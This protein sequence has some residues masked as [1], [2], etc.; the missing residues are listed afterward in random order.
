MRTN[1]I[2]RGVRLRSVAAG[3]DPDAPPRLVSIPTEWE[4]GAASALAGLVP[5]DGPVKLPEAVEAWVRPIA[6]A[7]Q[8]AGVR[9]DLAIRLHAMLLHRE[10]APAPAFWR[11]IPEEDAYFV[12]NLPA[13]VDSGASFDEEEFDAASETA[14]LALALAAP[15]AR[16]LSLG[17]AD[18]DGFIAA[19]GVPYGTEEACDLARFVIG[20]LR[21]NANRLCAHEVLAERSVRVGAF[22]PGLAEALLGAET[23]GI[24]PSFALVS[25]E[26]R[27]TRAARAFLAARGIGE[28]A[29]LAAELS[30]QS[31][32]PR[33]GHAAHRTMR[34]T[35]AGLL[36]VLPGLPEPAMEAEA[37]APASPGRR[38]L[39]DRHAGYTQ[40]ATLGGHRIYIRTG[41]YPDGTLGELSIALPKD[42]AALRGVM[43][44]FSTAVSIGLQHG[45]PLAEFV[46]AFT[47]LGR[48]GP[49]GVVEGDPAVLR[50]SSVPDYVFRHLA[51]NY[52]GQHDLPVP[53][54]EEPAA[55]Q[56]APLLP[57]DLPADPRAR[58][59]SFRVVSG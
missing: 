49:S 51:A 59:R 14:L 2:W 45:V 47:Q 29:A 12:L 4:D 50:A 58:R 24:A 35:L 53:E 8:R 46:E 43:D 42:S 38:D 20:R 56:P 44:A 54:S 6:L 39:P 28:G 11:G 25:A 22:A 55:P 16:T 34:A 36:D 52:L 41:E 21:A 23:G 33:S 48:F 10:A 5:G 3:A 26:G 37:G 40:K 9:E 32:F 30:G 1:Q 7:A 27:L 17:V 13:F 19:H 18:L 15:N 31:V 57:L